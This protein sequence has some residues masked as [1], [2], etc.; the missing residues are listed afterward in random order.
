M[1]INI[2][3]W[4]CVFFLS[5]GRL[6]NWLY[7]YAHIRDMR[8]RKVPVWNWYRQLERVLAVSPI[9]FYFF[10]GYFA[11]GANSLPLLLLTMI[12]CAVSVGITIFADEI[13][14]YFT[15]DTGTG[16]IEGKEK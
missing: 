13:L 12:W 1:D 8:R 7:V 6:A 11:W 14:D 10:L 9:A 3:L 4:I 15:T 16:T 2:F 5:I